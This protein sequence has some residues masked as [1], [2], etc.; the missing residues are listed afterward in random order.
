MSGADLAHRGSGVLDYVGLDSS[1]TRPDS[2][3]SVGASDT[4]GAWVDV[5]ASGVSISRDC[6]GLM[7]TIDPRTSN[8]A[9]AV[10]L[11]VGGNAIWEAF[12]FKPT[13]YVFA[14]VW[15]PLVVSGTLQYRVRGT[16]TVGVS[17]HWA[18]P[19]G[20]EVDR[21][22]RSETVGVS[23]SGA[24][25]SGTLV[26]PGATANAKGAWTEL[27]ASTAFRW[28]ALHMLTRHD[29]AVTKTFGQQWVLDVGVGAAGSEVV[30]V[31]NLCVSGATYH[32][33]GGYPIWHGPIPVDI[34][35]GS[36]VAVRAQTST[37]TAGQRDLEHVG[38]IGY[39]P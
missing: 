30:V 13:Y 19:G 22:T 32:I 36:R 4:W 21:F 10:Q 12:I 31:P 18:P 34:P 14:P 11:G 37:A 3:A 33:T 28:G 39:G 24:A 20:T 35:A 27:A 8:N 9:A 38:L 7:V 15:V 29:P 2:R 25:V 5:D 1:V 23:A 17:V 26:D 6:S 16:S